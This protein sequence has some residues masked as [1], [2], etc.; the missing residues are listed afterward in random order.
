MFNIG[1]FVC[2]LNYGQKLDKVLVC[3]MEIWK[4]R[5]SRQFGIDLKNVLT[6]MEINERNFSELVIIVKF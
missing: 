3:R 5:G 2:L 6:F 1:D 4:W